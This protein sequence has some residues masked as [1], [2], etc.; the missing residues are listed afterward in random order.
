M[1]EN[2]LEEQISPEV[3]RMLKSITLEE[4]KRVVQEFEEMGEDTT[5]MKHALED[6]EDV[7][8]HLAEL[9]KNHVEAQA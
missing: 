1:T 6:L 3:E 8:Q 5:Q 9:E 2:A 7:E 4:L